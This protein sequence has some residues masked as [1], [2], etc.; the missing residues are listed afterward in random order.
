MLHIHINYGL[1]VCARVRKNWLL[2]VRNKQDLRR[3]VAIPILVL[4]VLIMV[5]G[6]LHGRTIELKFAPVGLQPLSG[7][8]GTGVLV[9]APCQSNQNDSLYAF[10]RA[11][12][13][14]ESLEPNSIECAPC[15]QGCNGSAFHRAVAA[16]AVN[17]TLRP[18]F[19]AIGLQRERFPVNI[20][21]A[22]APSSVPGLEFNDLA[23]GAVT[24]QSLQLAD[25]YVPLFAPLLVRSPVM[26]V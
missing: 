26:S 19:A 16:Q 14:A 18:V 6:V 4:I 3:E 23:G 21:V 9:F 1:A 17:S 22:M 8:I 5:S 13:S 7:V 20:S 25:A 2:T 15:L 11:V 10:A 24:A 12:A